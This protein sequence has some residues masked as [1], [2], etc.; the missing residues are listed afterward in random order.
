MKYFCF[1]FNDV[2]SSES[3]EKLCYKY[4]IPTL[5]NRRTFLDLTFLHK[6]Y[7]STY[8]TPELLHEL[9]LRI[10]TF[11][12]KDKSLFYVQK[13]R[14]NVTKNSTMKRITEEFNEIL[15]KNDQLDL[16]MTNRVFS[17]SLRS[18][19]YELQE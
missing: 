19:L 10:P 18:I 6:I 3:Y 8:D 12:S 15:H 5:H 13:S 14:V 4:N 1:K 16:A 7:N 9:S 2:Y 11:L 17:K